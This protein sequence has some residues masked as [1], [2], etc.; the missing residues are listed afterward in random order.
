MSLPNRSPDH[1][2]KHGARFWFDEMIYQSNTLGVKKLLVIDG[3]LTIG[4]RKA[5]IFK[6]HIQDAYKNWAINKSESIMLE[7]STDTKQDQEE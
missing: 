2:T 4:S 1:I 3:K 5:H 6:P 7:D